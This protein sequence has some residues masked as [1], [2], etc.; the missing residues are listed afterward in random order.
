MFPDHFDWN[1]VGQET[2]L[3]QRAYGVVNVA[4]YRERH[5]VLKIPREIT[6]NGKE[7]VKEV[8]LLNSVRGHQNVVSFQAVCVRPYAIMTEYVVFF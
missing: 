2:L 5:V 1:E 7:F 3:G 4:H 6:G 8:K